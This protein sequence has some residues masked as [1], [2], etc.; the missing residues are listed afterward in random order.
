MAASIEEGR[1]VLEPI[2]VGVLVGIGVAVTG[3]IGGD[4]LDNR[5]K[6]ASS[7]EARDAEIDN[8]RGL[9]DLY[10]RILL[11]GVV[12]LVIMAIASSSSGNDSSRY[13][14]SYDDDGC[15]GRC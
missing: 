8:N 1:G 5:I 13:D 12:L 2:T 3:W 11:I 7:T 4:I 10:S 6:N 15:S 14:P 9:R